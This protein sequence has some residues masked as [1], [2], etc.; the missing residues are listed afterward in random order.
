MALECPMNMQAVGY[1]IQ[2]AG[3]L[4]WM[5]FYIEEFNHLICCKSLHHMLSHCQPVMFVKSVF[6]SSGVGQSEFA[7]ADMVDMFVL[8]IPPAGGDELQVGEKQQQL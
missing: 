4:F 6:L 2:T 3:S 7:V 5:Q 1:N 8:L